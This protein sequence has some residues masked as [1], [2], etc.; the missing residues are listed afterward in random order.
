MNAFTMNHVTKRFD[1][2]ALEDITLDLPE[3]LIMGLVGENGAGKTTLIK[4]LL[5]I[6]PIDSG[7]L[8]ILGCT[9]PHREKNIMND[10]GAVSDEMPL[11]LQLTLNETGRVFRSFY[12]NWDEALFQSFIRRLNVPADKQYYQLSRGNKMKAGIVCA[13][14]HHPKLLVLDEATSGLDP[15]VRD[16]LIDILLE[17]T[18]DEQH[19][20]LL[21]SHIISDLEKACDLI[22]FL[23]NGKLLLSEEKDVLLESYGLIHCPLDQLSLL[24]QHAVLGKRITPYGA[25]AVVRRDQI[26]DSFDVKPVNLEELFVQMVK[27]ESL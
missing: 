11:P 15:V 14:S 25:E 10:I 22:T 2:F 23:H 3:G 5:G 8:S 12:Q 27:G 21:S 20:I 7:S 17:F 24:E 18:R 13:L 26:P 4:S 9:D 6:H 19:S 16:E 1:E